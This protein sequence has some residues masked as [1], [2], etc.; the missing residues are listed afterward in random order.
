MA[1]VGY[2]WYKLFNILEMTLLV[3]KNLEILLLAKF[4]N[5]SFLAYTVDILKYMLPCL[6]VWIKLKFCSLDVKQQWNNISI[7]SRDLK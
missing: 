5:I 6:F 7:R 3:K 4:R 1:F 2:H